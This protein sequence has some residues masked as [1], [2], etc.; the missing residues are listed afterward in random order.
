L[1]GIYIL[2]LGLFS[3]CSV[4]AQTSEI[5]IAPTDNFVYDGETLHHY[6]V[7]FHNY[8][9]GLNGSNLYGSGYFGIDFFT[10]GIH[11]LR[12][13]HSGYVGIGTNSPV[14]LLDVNGNIKLG[15]STN[16]SLLHF[17]GKQGVSWGY[18]FDNQKQNALVIKSQ[19]EGARPFSIDPF[20]NVGFGTEIP[21]AQVHIM[22]IFDAGGRNLLIGDDSYLT[23]IDLG[24]TL[25]IYGNQNN[26]VGNLKLGASGPT[27]YGENGKLGIGVNPAGGKLHV[28]GGIA[29]ENPNLYFEA[30]GNAAARAG[31][32]FGTNH[33]T[34]NSM[35]WISPDETEG[36]RLNFG[37]GFRYDDR[38]SLLTLMNNGYVGIGTTTPTHKLDVNGTIR[39]KEIKVE[40]AN[41]PDYVF[42]DDYQLKNLSEVAK[43]IET[44]KH[45]PDVPAVST[46]DKEGI[47]LGEMNK[48]LLQKVEELTLYVIQLQKSLE[49][50][51]QRLKIVESTLEIKK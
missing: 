44:N 30:S 17:Y 50:K 14:Q 47:N 43:F 11:R 25:G 2:V 20:G 8:L 39:A 9:D 48:I 18:V 5:T 10:G 28:K 19:H 6:G 7:G 49:E 21:G 26:Q 51:D 16:G 33:P 1:K 34:N 36:N 41:W 46:V 32:M 15:N 35:F 24:N 23:D 29:I 45:L 38:Y 27:L 13:S 3:V 4:I 31:I 22:D 42:T 40:A 37:H 12:I